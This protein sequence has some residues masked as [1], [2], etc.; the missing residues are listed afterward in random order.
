MPWRKWGSGAARFLLAVL[1]IHNFHYTLSNFK[2][3][4]QHPLNSFHSSPSKKW[5]KDFFID[6]IEEKVASTELIGR[7][8]N[9]VAQKG[10][11]TYSMH[12]DGNPNVTVFSI[13]G[14]CGDVYV[15]H[16]IDREKTPSFSLTFDVRSTTNNERLANPLNVIIHIQ[17]INDNAPQFSQREFNI[18]IKGNYHKGQHFYRMTAFDSDQKGT[19]NSEVVYFL[20]SQMPQLKLPLFNIDSSTGSMSI[21]QCLDYEA[22]RKFRVLIMASDLGSPP[23]SSTATVNID[24]EDSNYNLPVFTQKHYDA[25]VPEGTSGINILRLKV[26]DKDSPNTRAWKAKYTIRTGNERGNFVVFTDSLTNEGIL[27]VAK[28]LVYGSLSVRRLVIVVENE[29]PFF[30]CEGGLQPP[31]SEVSVNINI[32]IRNYAPQFIPPFL[33][34]KYQEGVKGGT[35][36]VKYIAHDSDTAQDKIRY[37]IGFDPSGWLKISEYYGIVT[38]AKTLGREYLFLNKT[39][40]IHAIDDGIPPL[41]GTGT[42]QLYISPSKLIAVQ[43]LTICEGKGLGPFR[44]TSEVEDYNPYAGS[45]T[46]QLEDA[47]EGSQNFWRLGE[48]S[49]NSVQLFMLKNHSPGD[50]LV[51][52]RIRDL[53]GVFRQQTLN[54]QVCS[55]LDGIKCDITN[56]AIVEP[57]TLPLGGVIGIIVIIF[58]LLICDGLSILLLYFC[59]VKVKKKPTFIPYELGNQSLIDYKEESEPVLNA[60]GLGNHATPPSLYK[61]SLDEKQIIKDDPGVTDMKFIQSTVDPPAGS[62]LIYPL[63]RNTTESLKK[64]FQRRRDNITEGKRSWLYW[65]D[66]GVTDMKFIQS[67]VDPPAG[68]P[69]IYPLNRNT[70]EPLKKEFQRRRD[71]ITEGKRSWL[72]WVNFWQN[73]NIKASENFLETVAA[74]LKQKC[75]Q[76]NKLEDNMVSYMPHIYAE[77]GTLEK[78]K[79]LLSLLVPEDEKNSLPSNLLDDMG[80]IFDP[81]RKIYRK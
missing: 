49:G 23:M 70:T 10:P 38:I 35:T 30:L 22:N 75:K 76:I 67:T 26:E 27:Q 50:Y 62:P 65:D 2:G 46:F 63:N 56:M 64:E 59:I 72:Y 77:E 61:N 16:P 36:L 40:L 7:V 12:V 47:L 55:C 14:T 58:L 5:T 39:I 18:I 25:G 80:F 19:A 45:L 15:H 24:V 1:V 52:L 6:I 53:Q 4:N 79:S 28:P 33:H 9:D 44:I 41:T 31:F 3:Y 71:N 60:A 73:C 37:K 17:D 54:V 11:V 34:F 66:P 8:L 48:S 43:N 68:S 78:S 20:I 42:I 57:S 81:L 51:P 32:T 29:L 21:T 74:T 13:R 69:L